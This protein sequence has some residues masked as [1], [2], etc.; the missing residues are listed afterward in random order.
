M[1]IFEPTDLRCFM[2][3]DV[4]TLMHGGLLILTVVWFAPLC[5]AGCSGDQGGGLGE[6]AAKLREMVTAAEAASSGNKVVKEVDQ[7]GSARNSRRKS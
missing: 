6:L 3:G 4:P 2:A 1:N 5:A 7:R